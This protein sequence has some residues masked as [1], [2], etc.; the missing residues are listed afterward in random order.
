VRSFLTGIWDK[1]RSDQPFDET[2]ALHVAQELTDAVNSAEAEWTDIKKELVK[3]GVGAFSAGAMSA[4]P[5]IASG[6]ALWLAAASAV[7]TIG[8]GAWGRLQKKS[9]LT[10]HPAAFFM[11]LRESE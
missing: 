9:Y 7:G 5:A 8:F 2:A 11:D 6:H 10:K 1:L 3:Y 4:G